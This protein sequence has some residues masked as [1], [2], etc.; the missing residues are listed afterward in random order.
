[1]SPFEAALLLGNGKQIYLAE[2]T[3]FAGCS[4]LL[5]LYKT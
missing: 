5:A 2:Q 4:I 3:Y 1:M